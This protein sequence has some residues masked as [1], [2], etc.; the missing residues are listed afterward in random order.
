MFVIRNTTTLWFRQIKVNKKKNARAG[1][2]L[3]LGVRKP[4]LDLRHHP[5]SFP[6]ATTAAAAAA[7]TIAAPRAACIV[8]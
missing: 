7:S 6:V 5:P 1:P 4:R 8:A 3:V 2:Y